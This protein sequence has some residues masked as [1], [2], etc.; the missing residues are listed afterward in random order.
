MFKEKEHPLN[1]AS[2]EN[3]R[4]TQ[5]V[6]LAKTI[7]NSQERTKFLKEA[8]K[9]LLNEMPIIPIYSGRLIYMTNERLKGIILDN[10]GHADF[11][12]AYFTN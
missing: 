3:E 2:W 12:R 8:E 6:N 5:C 4:F 10:C 7:T 1:F 11:R 9:I